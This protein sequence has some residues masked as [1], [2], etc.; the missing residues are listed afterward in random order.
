VFTGL[1]VSQNA[2][3]PALCSRP[4]A[5]VSRKTSG[6]TPVD[7]LDFPVMSL[8]DWI[9]F[10]LGGVLVEVEQSR[11]FNHLEALTGIPAPEV[12][13]RLKASRFFRDE[14]IVK[15]FAPAEIAGHVNTILGKSLATTDIVHA[16]NAELGAEI[17]TTAEL[18]PSLQRKVKVGCLSNTNSIHW[19]TLL[20]SY[21]FMH[22]FDR[23][24]A[25]QL[26]GCAKP[27]REIYEK[28]AGFLGAQPRQILFFDDR[29]ENVE[30]AQRLGWHARLY[31][32]H[33]RLVADISQFLAL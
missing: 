32:G 30:M 11:I 26:M 25:S 6:L 12:A 31:V 10:D 23:R 13:E 22:L 7:L 4:P 14:F 19:D 24:F 20:K 28:A 1:P 18:L 9:L 8:I 2:C 15:E 3:V 17:S 16:V 27:G 29:I 33:E 5:R 21:P